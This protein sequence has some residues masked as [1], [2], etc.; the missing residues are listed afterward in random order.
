MNI[1]IFGTKKSSD[2]RKAERFF[3][4]RGIRE[5]CSFHFH[6]EVN[7]SSVFAASETMV[8]IAVDID[9][10]RR[11]F[12]FMER[13]AAGVP[14]TFAHE[15]AVIGNDAADVRSQSDGFDN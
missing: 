6:N 4:E 5:G 11:C 3:K 13:A 15:L 2:T 7:G 9:E 14:A 1:Q 12:F 8:R 10:E